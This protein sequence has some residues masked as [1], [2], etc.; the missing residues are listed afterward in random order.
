MACITPRASPYGRAERR[1]V[2]RLQDMHRAEVIPER[3]L[4]RVSKTSTN[5][6]FSAD[7]MERWHCHEGKLLAESRRQWLE[8]A[9]CRASYLRDVAQQET[10]GVASVEKLQK[11]ASLGCRTTEGARILH[12]PLTM[13]SRC[14]TCTCSRPACPTCWCPKAEWSGT[15]RLYASHHS[16]WRE[17]GVNTGQ[18]ITRA[19]SGGD[20]E[21]SQSGSVRRVQC[22]RKSTAEV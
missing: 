4:R 10:V 13:A 17:I 20:T 19:W 16:A 5:H 1:F 6:T 2:E 18:R 3:Q 11:E 12:A 8:G 9:D 14:A 21:A 15:R 22:R 7:A